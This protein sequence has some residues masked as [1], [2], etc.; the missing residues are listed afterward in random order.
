[1]KHFI[2]LFGI[3]VC[4][5]FMVFAQEDTEEDR[6]ETVWLSVGFNWGNYFDSG[7]DIGDFYSGSPGINFNTYSFYNQKNIG[8]FGNIGLMFPVVNTIENG[9]NPI[10]HGSYIIGIGFRYKINEKLN[11]HFGIGPNL[12]QYYLLNRV[13]DNIKYTDDRYALGIGGDIGLKYDL[14]DSI[15]I[16]FGTTLS[17]D[18]ASY[19][20]V[21]STN[22]N[23]TNR[24]EESRGWISNS[25]FG[26]KPYIAIGFNLYQKTSKVKMGKP[27]FEN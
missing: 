3:L 4:M 1:M 20:I 18:F 6:I 16:D 24:K 14:T 23:W 10:V 15:Y 19:R 9:Y 5:D 8:F 11:L 25:F 13:N 22:D 12:E 26:I 7:T 17:Y 21:E 27:K 2:V